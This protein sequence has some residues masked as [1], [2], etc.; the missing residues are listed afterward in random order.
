MPRFYFNPPG[1]H[2]NLAHD[3]GLDMPDVNAA[4][5]EAVLAAAAMLKDA[6]ARGDDTVSLDVWDEQ[7]QRS[8]SVTARI[9]I[10]R[11]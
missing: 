8:C 2:D 4:C 3:T 6:A 7:G 10:A 11:S 9:S 5:L 1:T